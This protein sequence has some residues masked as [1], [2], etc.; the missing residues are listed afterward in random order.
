MDA[1]KR[2]RFLQIPSERQRPERVTRFDQ[3]L[4]LDHSREQSTRHSRII[5]GSTGVILPDRVV[6]L[7]R[8]YLSLDAAKLAGAEAELQPLFVPLLKTVNQCL[9]R[10]GCASC[11]NPEGSNYPTDP[12]LANRNAAATPVM[13]TQRPD[14]EGD[15]LL[16]DWLRWKCAGDFHLPLPCQ[17]VCYR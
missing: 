16:W 9:I 5:S 14:V 7:V 1:G 13:T 3:V 8:E 15:C 10:C 11:V 4:E 6:S 12:S 17:T 2:Q